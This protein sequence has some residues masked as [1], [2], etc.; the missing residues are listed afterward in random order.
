MHKDNHQSPVAVAYAQAIFDLANDA[1]QLDVI[2]DELANIRRIMDVLPS[3]GQLISDPAIS[4]AGSPS[5][6]RRRV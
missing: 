2:G 6:N 3:F 5:G 1:D 4:I